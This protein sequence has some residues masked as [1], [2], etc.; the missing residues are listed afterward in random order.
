MVSET[1]PPSFAFGRFEFDGPKGKLLL[2]G[3]EIALPPRELQLLGLFLEHPAE[4]LTQEGLAHG[5][6]PRAVPPTGELER[7]IRELTAALDA[8]ADGVATIQSLKGRGHRFLLPVRASAPP[9]AQG[10]RPSP[11]ARGR[12]AH[13]RLLGPRQIVLALL[14]VGA[15]AAALLWVNRPAQWRSATGSTGADGAAARDPQAL[16]A[17]A[18]AEWQRG[19]VAARQPDLASRRLAVSRFE[20]ALLLDPGLAAAHAGLAHTLVLEGLSV[21]GG[22]EEME[23][24]RRAAEAALALD[25]RLPDAHAALAFARLF[26]DRAPAV[27]RAAAERALALDPTHVGGRRALAWVLAVEGRFLEAL[28]QLPLARTS[29]E[30]DPE[31]ACDE[32]AILYLA[33]RSLEARRQLSESSA[34]AALSPCA[35]RAGLE[36]VR[37]EPLFR[38]AHAALAALHLRDRR[39]GAAAFELEM[40]DA[41][42]AGA[43]RDDDRVRQRAAG[44]WAMPEA[45]EAARLLA[46]RAERALRTPPG[47]ASG[48][49][50][51][52][53]RIFAQFG[54]H[55]RAIAALGRALD[56]RESA[57]AL[58]R[59][60]PAFA[61][62]RPAADFRELLARAGIPGLAQP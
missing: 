23:R 14:G 7:L 16:R 15:L 35:R 36:V 47:G 51:E 33:G 12:S 18:T 5:L 21:A 48:A 8:G 42:A 31:V 11:P 19:V 22:G 3:R 9:G 59:I 43:T 30:V 46:E 34:G 28:A 32:G 41:L 29:T 27:A 62:L 55:E 57:A 40:L 56:R 2:D 44:S 6:W 13:R 24:A 54:D 61:A 4:W 45:S 49:Q 1:S 25:E 38:R 20:A 37:R 60:D 52:A 10:T 58:A 26:A 50:L 39:L 17:A 53:A